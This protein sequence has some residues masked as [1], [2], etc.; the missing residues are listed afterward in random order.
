LC[1]IILSILQRVEK[2]GKGLYGK[3]ELP[4]QETGEAHRTLQLREEILQRVGYV[5]YA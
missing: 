2:I 5:G 3:C 4:V 1:I